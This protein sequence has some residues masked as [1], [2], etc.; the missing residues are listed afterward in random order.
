MGV[1]GGLVPCPEAL[2]VMI[3]AVG[4]NR[5]AFGLGLILSFSLGLAA[6][7]IGFGLVLVRSRALLTRIDRLSAAWTTLLPLVSAAVVTALGA[8]LILKAIGVDLLAR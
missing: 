7:L 6:V 5:T 4:V 8:G 3:L 2:G 1:S